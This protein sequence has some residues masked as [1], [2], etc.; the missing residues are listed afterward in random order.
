MIRNILTTIIILSA[1]ISSSLAQAESEA[2]T[3]T[4]K[5]NELMGLIDRMYVEDVDREQLELDFIRGMHN[6]LSPFQAYHKDSLL[7]KYEVP[8]QNKYQGIGIS[9]KFKGDTLLVK[10][11]IPG[12]GA[13][14][15]KIEEGDK[16]TKIGDQGIEEFYSYIDITR[17]LT[18]EANS[19]L[20]LTLV[21]G[22]SSKIKNVLRNE[23][24]GYSFTVLGDKGNTASINEYEKALN[25]FDAVYADTVTNS[26]IVETG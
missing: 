23:C 2:Y 4:Y 21:D 25:Y 16:I 12:S 22:D 26:V 5:V 9:F 8:I 24:N 7:K 11:V 10:S 1:A 6:N 13:D 19:A 15:A 14:N 18:G 3:T 20:N 17:V